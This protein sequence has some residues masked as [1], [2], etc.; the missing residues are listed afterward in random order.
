[1]QSKQNLN[2]KE[3]FI[4]IKTHHA[5]LKVSNNSFTTA[6]NT[7]GV[8]YIVRDPRDVV[9]SM[10][11]HYKTSIEKSIDTL[12]NENLCLRWQDTDNLYENRKKPLSI[13]SSWD[14]HFLS[15]NKYCF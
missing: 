11:N 14:K 3:D 10:S 7:R 8:I 1:M 6:E 4:F 9:V 15:W 2:L 13:I 12:F 5:L